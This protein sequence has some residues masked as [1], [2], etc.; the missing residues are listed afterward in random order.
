V[1]VFVH[2]RDKLQG[3]ANLHFTPAGS[4]L[5]G[6]QIAAWML[7][8]LRQYPCLQ[9]QAAH[10]KK[11]PPVLFR[12]PRANRSALGGGPLAESGRERFRRM[13]RY[14]WPKFSTFCHLSIWL[15]FLAGMGHL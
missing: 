10:A 13:N 12:S 11:K 7:E 9:K 8:S 4:Q 2:D 1:Q 15:R 5:M 6:K 3:F 14:S